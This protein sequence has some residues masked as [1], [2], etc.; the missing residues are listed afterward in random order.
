LNNNLIETKY[1]NFAPRLG[2]AYSL[3][4]KTVIRT[5]F[6]VFYNQDIG[7]AMY[8]DLARNIAARVTINSDIG[9]PTLRWSNAIPGGNGAVAQVPPP[10]AYVAAYD[11]ATSYTMQYLLNVQRQFGKDWVIELGY[12]G[13]ESH[14][15]YGFQNLNQAT[16]GTVGNIASRTSFKNYGVIQYVSDGLNAAYNSGSIKA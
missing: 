16:P 10:Y 3:N 2:I 1:R 7:N 15:L 4:N 13:S 6:G 5:G 9:N 12:L 8:F 14:H 11:H